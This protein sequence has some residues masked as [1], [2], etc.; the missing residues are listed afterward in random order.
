MR[1]IIITCI[2][3]LIVIGCKKEDVDSPAEVSNLIASYNGSN[4]VLTWTDPLDHDLDK[5]EIT[6][7]DISI[8]VIKGIQLKEINNLEIGKN[9]TFTIKTIDKIGNKSKG[10]QIQYKIDYRLQFTGKFSFTS[11]SIYNNPNMGITTYSDTINFIGNVSIVENS[12]SIIRI[13]Y[14]SGKQTYYCKDIGIWG[15]YIEPKIRANGVLDYK[16]Y[17]ES[18]CLSMAYCVGKYDQLNEIKIKLGIYSS[19]TK[20]WHHNINGVRIK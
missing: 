5:I 10:I 2:L 6:Y 19:S 7:E 9:Y 16:K 12:D 18:S 17:I 1:T 8:E 14:T 15:S 11:Y 4:V 20:A 3:L 13:T